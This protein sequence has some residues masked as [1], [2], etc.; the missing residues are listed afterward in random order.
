MRQKYSTWLA[1]GLGLI[2]LGLAISFA[3]LQSL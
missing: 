2:I 3:L 1:V